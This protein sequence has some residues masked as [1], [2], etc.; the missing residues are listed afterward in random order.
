MTNS[1]LSSA[2]GFARDELLELVEV[3]QVDTR[4]RTV[5]PDI[6]KI[7]HPND[8]IPELFRE[9]DETTGEFVV[10]VLDSTLFFLTHT[11]LRARS[12]PASET[13]SR[14]EG[15][16]RRTYFASPPDT[17]IDSLSP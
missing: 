16:L 1:V 6:F 14:R 17:S 4:P 8:G 2:F 11:Q 12:A 5:L 7:F 9:R 10:R 3:L 13:D 15:Y